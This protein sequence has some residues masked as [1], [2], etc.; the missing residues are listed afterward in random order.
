MVEKLSDIDRVEVD[1]V[2][3]FANKVVNILCTYVECDAVSTK[4]RFSKKD[5]KYIEIKSPKA[6]DVNNSYM[7]GVDL[8]DS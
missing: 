6:V 8:L 1:L 5:K 3:W 4:K 2:S 7:G